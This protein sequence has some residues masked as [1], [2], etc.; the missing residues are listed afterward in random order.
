MSEPSAS[1]EWLNPAG[2]GVR[3]EFKW[4]GDRHQHTIFGVR[5]AECAPLLV[6]DESSD[7]APALVELQRHGEAIL[8][9]GSNSVGHW[10]LSV[11]KPADLS[12]ACNAI[13]FD[14]ACRCKKAT[15]NIAVVYRVRQDVLC[16]HHDKGH[17]GFATPRQSI[18][19]GNVN[20]D[21]APSSELTTDSTDAEERSGHSL[22]ASSLTVS[23]C[24]GSVKD[25]RTRRWRYSVAWGDNVKT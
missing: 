5:G 2:N 18:V 10:S 17:A 20:I 8:L 7:S 13:C 4:I 3:V 24:Q 14:F 23:P 11:Q 9:T 6:S 12:D 25:D 19:F 1:L 22:A 16:W 21:G 15:R